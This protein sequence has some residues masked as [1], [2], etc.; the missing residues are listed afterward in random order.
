MLLVR[1]PLS[2]ARHLY[3]T[4]L[5]MLALQTI[6]ADLNQQIERGRTMNP[7]LKFCSQ[8]HW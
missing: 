8:S 2:K 3:F 1:A 6:Q 4:F 7:K 5:T